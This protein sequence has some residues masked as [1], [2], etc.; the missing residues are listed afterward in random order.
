MP[1]AAAHDPVGSYLRE[2]RQLVVD[3]IRG[4]VPSDP[5]YGPILYDLVLDYP[6]REAKALRPALC[7][8]VCRGLGGGLAAV[9]PSAAVLE[10]YHNAFL[11]HDDVEDGSELRR[12]RTTL[13]R[14]HG[15]PVAINVG[16]AMLA[17]TLRPLLDNTRW[18]GLGKALRVLDT[19][20]RMAQE[21]AEGQA[22]E[23]DWIRHD[24]WDLPD[25]AYLRMVAKKTAWYSFVAP[26]TIG[27]TVAGRDRGLRGPIEELGTLLGTAFQIQDDVLNLVAGPGP[28]GKEGDGDLWE[29][30][31]TLILLHAL[32]VARDVDRDRARA[33]LSLPRPVHRGDEGSRTE[34]G[35]TFLRDLVTRCGSIDHATGV[36]RDHAR[37]ARELLETIPLPRS[38]H[39]DFLHAL[40][41]FVVERSH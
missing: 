41:D 19:V 12:D 3:Q 28:Y 26:M 40:I 21:S 8:A 4:F 24:R 29:G 10:L 7:I 22:L 13:H 34:E 15:S 17:L 31:R 11:V 30:K 37:R 36:A 39:R 35:V 16:D 23:L 32:R 2:C 1:E 18:I 27:A 25:A 6:L 14:A 33:I 5:E 38:V 20:A 9:L